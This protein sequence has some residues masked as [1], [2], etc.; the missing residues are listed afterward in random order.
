MWCTPAFAQLLSKQDEELVTHYFRYTEGAINM[1]VPV[2]LVGFI[3]PLYA[4][5]RLNYDISF[6]GSVL[7]TAA[8][9][10]MLAISGYKTY[11]SFVKKRKALAEAV[12]AE[13]VVL[14]PKIPPA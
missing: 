9:A 6:A 3:F 5:Q 10:V 7:V 4:R 12:A 8:L 13:Q 11:L 2:I 1:I 14:V